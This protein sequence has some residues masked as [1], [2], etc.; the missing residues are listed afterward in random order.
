MLYQIIDSRYRT[1]KPL[2]ITTNLSL[3][4]LREKLTLGD[5]IDRT[6]D[7]IIE[8]CMPLEVK[9]S[10]HRVKAARSKRKHLLEM[11]RQEEGTI[12]KNKE[13]RTVL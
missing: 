8:A 1:G 7:R 4:Q 11:L 13:K 6:Y 12:Q 5:G 3:D 10:S 2:L 9:G